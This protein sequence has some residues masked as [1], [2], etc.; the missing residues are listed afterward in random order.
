MMCGLFLCRSFYSYELA[1]H[2]YALPLMRSFIGR[3]T[4]FP[5]PFRVY[6]I[7]KKQLRSLT[8]EEAKGEELQLPHPHNSMHIR[9]TPVRKIQCKGQASLASP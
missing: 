3:L 6:Y 8:A 1:D 7:E 4:A 9:I 2:I 5:F